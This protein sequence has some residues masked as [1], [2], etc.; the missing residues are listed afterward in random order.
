MCQTEPANGTDP[1][2]CQSTQYGPMKFYHGTPSKERQTM[3][4]DEYYVVPVI[5]Y[6]DES[7]LEHNDYGFCGNMA[8]ECHENPESI[9]DLNQEV[10][11]GLLTSDDADLIYRDKT[12]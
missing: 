8:H 7:E 5:P 3:N 4:G 2:L 6:D 1:T 11:D 10:Q 9:E 12:V